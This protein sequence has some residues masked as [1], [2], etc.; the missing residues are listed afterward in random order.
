MRTAFSNSRKSAAQSL[1]LSNVEYML[2][3]HLQSADRCPTYCSDPDD[4]HTNPTEVIGPNIPARIENRSSQSCFRI[5]RRLTCSLSQRTGDTRQREI[6]QRCR[7][8]CG[9]RNSVINVK[10][11]FLSQLGKSAILAAILGALNGR[12]PEGVR[13]RHALMRPACPNARS[14]S[15]AKTVNRSTRPNPR[16]RGVRCPSAAVLSLACP[17]VRAGGA[18]R[19]RA[20]EADP[21]RQAFRLRIESSETYARINL[22]RN[23]AFATQNSS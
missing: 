12:L 17:T 1:L 5:G 22:E 20:G 15:G 4:S 16:L 23:C 21:D 3:V 19:L 2:A 11:G 7:A 6:L 13:N 10:A 18:R 8:A 14:A 9:L